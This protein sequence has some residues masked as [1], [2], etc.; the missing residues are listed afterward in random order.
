MLTPVVV[1]FMFLLAK[2][3]KGMTLKIA[4]IEN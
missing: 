1:L 2:R 3:I 4:V